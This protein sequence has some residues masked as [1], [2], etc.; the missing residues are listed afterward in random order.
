[1]L[2]PRNPITAINRL[3]PTSVQA[4]FWV[5]ATLLSATAFATE[6]RATMANA[7]PLADIVVTATR[8]PERRI[9]LPASIDRLDARALR[10]GQLGV[11]LSETLASVPGL[12]VQ[13]RQIAVTRLVRCNDHQRFEENRRRRIVLR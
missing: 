13:S 9:D 11:N 5:G 8:I 4:L 2:L 12:S 1:M 6:A 7:G 3:Q 10:E